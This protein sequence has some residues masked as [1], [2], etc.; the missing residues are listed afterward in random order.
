VKNFRSAAGVPFGTQNRQDADFSEH[1]I[2]H[3]N[4]FKS[5]PEEKLPSGFFYACSSEGVSKPPGGRLGQNG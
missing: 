3:G 5:N 4:E 1:R 2:F